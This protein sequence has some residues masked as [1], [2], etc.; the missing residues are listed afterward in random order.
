MDKYYLIKTYGCQMN[1]HDSEKIAGMLK[2]LGYKET[3]SSTQ[4]DVVVF[5]TCCI[6]D[7][8]EQKISAH[9]GTFKNIKKNKPSQIIIVCGCFSQEK[10][11]AELLKKRFPFIDI[12]V[13]TFNN[14]EIKEKLINYIESRKKIIDIWE[15]E[16]GI[17]ENTDIY[18]TSGNN[19]WVNIS[20]GCNNFCTY[21]IVPYVRGRERSR[22][23]E[24]IYKE[25]K[26]LVNQ[27]Y[28]YITLLG[29]NVNS[30]GNDLNDEK[31]N[32]SNLLNILSEIEGDYRI[33]FMTSHPKDLSSELIK[34]IANNPKI[35]K[36]IHLPVQ[37]G[38][39]KILKLMNRN[40]T[41]EKYLSIIDEIRENIP[42]ASIT[43]DIIVGF[44][45]ETDEDFNETLDLIQKVKYEGVFAFMYSKRTG[46]IAASM[47]NQVPEEI[48]N[49]RVNKVLELQK[50]ISEEN[51]NNMIN[52]VY[53]GLITE[54]LENCNYKAVLDFGK[55]III[56][57]YNESIAIP[58]FKKIK[59]IEIKNKKFYGE[60]VD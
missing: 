31:T 15:K 1:I 38:S 55:D 8:V 5:N 59:I 54:K 45:S 60:I 30:Y 4:A 27:G 58:S 53:D 43:T 46:T 16:N 20:Y 40:Y 21:C 24:D 14:H 42:N 11:K 56:R 52:K 3:K 13:G 34:T 7:G 32:F 33:K 57:S 47:E 44:P 22:K 35:C 25:V 37:A 49:I 28:K 51:H 9:I 12:I 48:K 41:R 23:M 39:N 6:R 19:A 50:Q 18:R 29:Q 10:D 26:I 2:D 36:C 17:F